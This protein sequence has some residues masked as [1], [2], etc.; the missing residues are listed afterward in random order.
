M[1]YKTCS[2]DEVIASV[3]RNTRLYDA[4]YIE[5]MVEWIPEA[6]S[7]LHT[8]TVCSEQYA[9]CLIDF[10]K[11]KLPCGLISI[12]AIE[13]KGNRLRSSTSAKHYAT[14]SLANLYKIAGVN[15]SVLGGINPVTGNFMPAQ[16]N[17]TNNIPSTPQNTSDWY[18]IEM[19]YLT[20][21]IQ[22]GYLR[23]YYLQRPL[24]E[25]GLPL[26]PDNQNYKEALYYYVRMKMIGAGYQDKVYRET[27]LL[28]RFELYGARAMNEI[29][30]PTVDMREAQLQ[31]MTRFIP[32]ANYYERYFETDSTGIDTTPTANELVTEIMGS[33]KI[34]MFYN[35]TSLTIEHNLKTLTPIVTIYDLNG[36]EI[37]GVITAT[38]PDHI[39][40]QFNP[41][42]SG[43]VEI[44]K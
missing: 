14:G 29:T 11:V 16:Q 39:T 21:N 7:L 23:I 34:F 27:E 31:A 13:Y 9:D 18:K 41:A 44:D 15:S 40:I 12:K 3:I 32:P 35:K 6:M 36:V 1:I 43:K 38:D 20:T 25:N 37:S 28:G 19:D 30:Y 26:I 2:I 8:N 33:P 22:E 24:D 42:Q 10:H 17:N 4:T 5:D